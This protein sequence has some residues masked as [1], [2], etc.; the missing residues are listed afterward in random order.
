VRPDVEI[1]PATST[2][3]TSGPAGAEAEESLMRKVV[4]GLAISLDSVVESP[5]TWDITPYFD[6]EVMEV[7]GVGCRW[8]NS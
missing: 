3:R 6:D 5:G 7:I 4:A 8:P 1:G 2:S